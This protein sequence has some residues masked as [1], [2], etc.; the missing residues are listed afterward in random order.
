[1]V[2]QFKEKEWAKISGTIL[3]AL[4]YA[5]GINLF[6]VPCNLYTGGLLGLAQ[7]IRTMMI[8]WF[9]LPLQ[10]VDLSGIIYMI[11]NIPLFLLAY[12]AM[13]RKFFIR[14]VIAVT[15][16]TVAL[17]VITVSNP[18]IDDTLANCLIGGIISGAGT[19]IILL[20]TASGGGLDVLGLYFTLK[21]KNMSFGKFTILFNAVIYLYCLL[22]FSIEVVIFSIIYTVF[23]SLIVDRMHQQNISVKVLVFT[24][25]DPKQMENDIFNLLGRGVTTWDG[26]GAYTD[27]KTNIMCICLSKFEVNQM[28]KI[29]H[30]YDKNAFFIIDEGV[31]VEGNYTKKL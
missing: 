19:G 11:L 17:S 13:G 10:N 29:V 18:I 24:K 22:S 27:E 7:I 6:I 15:V 31:V 3:G 28:K 12:K 8:E 23:Y 1:M 2:E 5:A 9:N 25:K 20:S 30:K 14:T 16:M 26:S 4:L 21:Y